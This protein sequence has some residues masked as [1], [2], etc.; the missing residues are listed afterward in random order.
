MLACGRGSDCVKEDWVDGLVGRAPCDR[1]LPWAWDQTRLA[2]LARGNRNP[3]FG[4]NLGS[5][6][7]REIRVPLEKRNQ[8]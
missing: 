1:D 5:L 6:G 3:V 7:L 2:D 8:L 4:E